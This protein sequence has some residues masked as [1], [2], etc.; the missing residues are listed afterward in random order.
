MKDE[1]EERKEKIYE[2]K[3]RDKY[4]SKFTERK[5]EGIKHYVRYAKSKII[6]IQHVYR[7]SQF[8]FSTSWRQIKVSTVPVGPLVAIK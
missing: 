3:E 8:I 5:L 1:R 7:V 6:Y 2:M 4:N